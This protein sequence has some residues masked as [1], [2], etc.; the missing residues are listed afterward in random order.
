MPNLNSVPVPQYQA[1]QPYHYSYDNLPLQ[2]LERRDEVINNA[3]DIHAEILRDGAGTQ[4]TLS[5]RLNQSL[6]EDGNLI[7]AAVDQCLHNIAEHSDGSKN[8]DAGELITYSVLGY[9]TVANPVS[10]VRMLEL[11]RDK[12]ALVADEATNITISVETISS[13]VLVDQGNFKI[14]ESSDI[15]WQIEPDGTGYK[16]KP[17]LKINLDQAHQHNYGVVPNLVSAGTPV[18][19]ETPSAMAYMENSLRV[20]VNGIRLNNSSTEPVSYP[21][22]NVTFGDIY[23]SNYYTES[24]PS[25]GQFE[26]NAAL[27][28]GDRIRID[29]DISL[30]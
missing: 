22:T 9:T 23:D 21:S 29:Y 7:P 24:D 8:V 2:A 4:G 6:D 16:Y 30:T 20:Y 17:V 26:L 5:N 13:V 18:V 27:N 28:T 15:E 10:F 1:G 14:A 3:V 12:L 11:E 19:Y 25:A